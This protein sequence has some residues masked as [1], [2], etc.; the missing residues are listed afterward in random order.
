MNT[1]L[2][3]L[4]AFAAAS[5]VGCSPAP[6]NAAQPQSNVTTA[7]AHQA[8]PSSRPAIAAV[9]THEVSDYAT[10]KQVFDGDSGA[11]Q[12]AGILGT[13]INRGADNPNLIS[14]Y[15]G[16]GD[17]ASLRGFLNNDDLKA[18][19]TRAGVKGPP[20]VVLMT[21]VEDKPVR[22]RALPGA[23][24]SHRVASYENWKKVFDEDAPSRAKAGIV[25]YAINRGVDDPNTVIVYLQ[26]ATL[27]QVRSFC[28]SPALKD[29]MAKAGVEG[30]PRIAFVQGAD[31]GP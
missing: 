14:V 7:G 5:I 20:T 27:E 31:W 16:A 30:A 19:M 3:S 12:R 1:K 13:H 21:P 9:V 24:V 11:R 10:W 15:L 6:N 29:T 17:A 22:D 26:S 2:T 25:G 23:I 4:A 18:T 28:A 8:V